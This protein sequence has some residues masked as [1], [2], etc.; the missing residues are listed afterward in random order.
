MPSWPWHLTL[1]CELTEGLG[2]D[3]RKVAY[4][5]T[6]MF[7]NEAKRNEWDCGAH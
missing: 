7:T 3:A 6:G 5:C 2:F 4:H 1:L